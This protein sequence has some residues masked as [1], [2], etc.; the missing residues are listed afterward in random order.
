MSE[1]EFLAWGVGS[2]PWNPSTEDIGASLAESGEL[3]EKL[4]STGLSHS[5]TGFLDVQSLEVDTGEILE[6]LTNLDSTDMFGLPEEDAGYSPSVR[7][8]FSGFLPESSFSDNL[9]R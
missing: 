7:T 8:D 4:G 1:C 9:G 2:W 6:P 3:S 5:E